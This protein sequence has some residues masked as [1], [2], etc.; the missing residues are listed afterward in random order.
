MLERRYDAWCRLLAAFRAVYGGVQHDRLRLPAYG[1]SLFDPDRFPFLEGR[2]PRHR[3]GSTTRR[4]TRCPS[5]TAPCCTCWRRC[6]CCRCKVPGG[7]PAEAR[8]LS[9]RALDIEQIGH[10]YE[11]LLDHTAV[12]ADEPVLGL[13]GTKDKEPE[14]PLSV[15]GGASR[16]KGEAA[17][18][19]FLKDETGRTRRRPA[20]T[21]LQARLSRSDDARAK[22]LRAACGNDEAL[23][24]ARAA[25]CRAG[26][27]RR[28]SAARSSSRRAAST[29]PPAPTRRATGT[30]YTPRSLTEPIVQHT[31][32]PLVYVG[33]AEGKPREEWALRSP[34]G[35]P[36][37]QGLRHGHGLRR[38]PGAGL[39]LPV[40]A[41]GRG[42]GRR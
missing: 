15:T 14:I 34:G 9:F 23:Y 18:V 33:P 38:L 7:G 37:P 25:L 19:K 10:V 13:A 28:L 27:R 1:G 42:R 39:P 17:L 31:L 4:A 35:A 11:G 32:E 29:S 20:A 40:R 36:R 26:P 16:R 12:R 30:H 21:A 2:A 8:R 22:R 5:T 6:R 24:A 3:T 41:A